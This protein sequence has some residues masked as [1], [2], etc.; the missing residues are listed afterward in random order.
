MDSL[1]VPAQPT[2]DGRVEIH[3]EDELRVLHDLTGWALAGGHTL[4]GLS[5]LRVSLEDI[6]LGLTRGRGGTAGGRIGDGACRWGDAAM[7]TTDV[8]VKGSFRGVSDLPLVARQVRFEQ[9]SFWLNPIGALLTIGFSLI[10]IVIFESTSRHATVGY[11]AHINLG[12]VL[13][14]GLLPPTASWPPVSTSW[15]SAW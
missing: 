2:D 7:S 12:P 13:H 10:F 6:Y 5:V 8:P 9:L 14:P 15:P 1:P 3:T 11:L 4:A